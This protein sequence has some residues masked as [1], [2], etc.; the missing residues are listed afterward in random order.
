MTNRDTATTRVAASLLAF[1]AAVACQTSRT[2]TSTKEI[3]SQKIWENLAVPSLP[4][5]RRPCLKVAGR[6]GRR[7]RPADSGISH[8]FSGSARTSASLLFI[9]RSDRPGTPLDHF[10]NGN[11][12]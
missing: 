12:S 4:G 9:K 2:N 11:V 6:R 8:P 3:R 10:P 7:V 1:V 5:A